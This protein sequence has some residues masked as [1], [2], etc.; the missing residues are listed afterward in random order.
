M[1][2]DTILFCSARCWNELILFGSGDHNKAFRYPTVWP[3]YTVDF[4]STISTFLIF[5]PKVFNFPHFVIEFCFFFM[6]VYCIQNSSVIQ[7]FEFDLV[8]PSFFLICCF[9]SFMFLPAPL[10]F[11]IWECWQGVTFF[12]NWQAFFVVTCIYIWHKFLLLEG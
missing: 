3:F 10:H 12:S 2:Y 1:T 5:V 7:S 6:E 11:Y 9:N 8:F 4:N